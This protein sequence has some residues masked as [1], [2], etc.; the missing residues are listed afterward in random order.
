M[1]MRFGYPVSPNRELVAL[2]AGNLLG[3]LI[4][5]AIPVAGSITR[6]ENLNDDNQIRD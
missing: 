6:C 1:A 4:P 3:S 2:G 5:G